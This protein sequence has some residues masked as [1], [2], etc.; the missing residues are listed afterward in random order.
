[1]VRAFIAWLPLK[2]CASSTCASSTYVAGVGFYHKFHGYPDPT[3]DILVS[4]LLEGC[5][6]DRQIADTRAPSTVPI[7]ITISRALPHV[8]ESRFEELLF[9]AAMLCAFLGS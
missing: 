2:G 1:M 4:K 9:K 3:K 8:C 5:R 7:L 6:R